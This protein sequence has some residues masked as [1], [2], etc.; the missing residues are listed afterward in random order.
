MRNVVTCTNCGLQLD[1]IDGDPELES[2]APACAREMR[3]LLDQTVHQLARQTSIAS[4]WRMRYYRVVEQ[5]KAA[6][7]AIPIA[8]ALER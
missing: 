1:E 4:V 6:K 5:Q 2:H 8:A 3:A 7:S